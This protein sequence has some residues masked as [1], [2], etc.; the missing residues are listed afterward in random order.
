M[1]DG[2]R[3]GL[4]SM[5]GAMGSYGALLKDSPAC[6]REVAH[7]HFVSDRL[8]ANVVDQF[9]ETLVSP[10]AAAAS[11]GSFGAGVSEPQVF[12]GACA[13]F[14]LFPRGRQDCRSHWWWKGCS[15]QS[16]DGGRGRLVCSQGDRSVRGLFKRWRSTFYRG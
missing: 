16:K 8:P 4:S 2:M 10:L 13:D 3:R 6:L 9:L 14:L 1:P 15:P 12:Q 11:C 5:L 7:H